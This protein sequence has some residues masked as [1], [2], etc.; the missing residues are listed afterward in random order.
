[1]IKPI[2]RSFLFF[3]FSRSKIYARS[4]SGTGLRCSPRFDASIRA[5]RVQKNSSSSAARPLFLTFCHVSLFVPVPGSTFT[6]PG[7]V[8]TWHV[9]LII[10][11]IL[12]VACLTETGTT[13]ELLS[14]NI[15]AVINSFLPEGYVKFEK[16]SKKTAFSSGVLSETARMVIKQLSSSSLGRQ[17]G[18]ELELWSVF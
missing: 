11:M 14:M 12:I 9:C 13:E 6:V 18:G 3:F 2:S 1:M 10:L 17:G 8:K 16:T 4:V 5:C 7:D 15:L